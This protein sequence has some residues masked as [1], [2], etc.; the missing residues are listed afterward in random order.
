M[1]QSFEAIRGARKGPQQ[2][3]A[4]GTSIDGWGARQHGGTPFKAL[5]PYR[6][7]TQDKYHGA[8]FCNMI[9]LAAFWCFYYNQ[10]TS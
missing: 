6:F 10:G 7:M 8:G 9:S 4:A 1:E 3:P 5:E 2:Q